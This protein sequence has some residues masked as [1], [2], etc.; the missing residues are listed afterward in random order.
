[1]SDELKKALET[2]ARWDSD[3]RSGLPASPAPPLALDWSQVNNFGYDRTGKYH[4]RKEMLA[5]ITRLREEVHYA[6]GVAELAM[7]HRDEAE[8]RVKELDDVLRSVRLELSPLGM[9]HP[10]EVNVKVA[11]QWIDA[12]L[13][14]SKGEKG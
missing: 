3:P 10:S 8:V 4:P 2:I 7:K 11:C 1:M 9:Y 6:N 5:E 12:A 13:S 14:A